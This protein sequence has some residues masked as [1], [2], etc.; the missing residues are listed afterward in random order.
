LTRI[1][2]TNIMVAGLVGGFG[3]DYGRT[4]GAH[5]IHDALTG[6]PEA[7]SILHGNK[8]AYGV[9]IQLVLEQN[10][11][12][13]DF[14]LPFYEKLVL[15]VSLKD[16]GLDHLAR[17]DLLQL[18]ERATVEQASIHRMPGRI[19]ADHVADA[20]EQL[21]NYAAKRHTELNRRKAGIL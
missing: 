1:A 17:K 9:L 16:M 7:H 13:I 5:S 10:W 12:E 19:E 21:E 3:E 15:P 18:G 8:V 14:L 2:E 20:M 6:I 11:P 4:A